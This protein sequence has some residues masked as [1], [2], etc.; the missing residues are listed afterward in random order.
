MPGP[1]DP[2]A[3]DPELARF[4]DPDIQ[5][6][7]HRWLAEPP[8]TVDDRGAR[9]LARHLGSACSQPPAWFDEV[10]VIADA[11]D[12]ER[13]H[14]GEIAL[15]Q[16]AGNPS[17]NIIRGTPGTGNSLA[18]LAPLRGAQPDIVHPGWSS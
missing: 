18:D 5:A 8:V 15:H 2:D 17:G 14:P 12:L 4:G 10:V 1:D 9:P 7:V 11:D 16:R 6:R 3:S 13:I